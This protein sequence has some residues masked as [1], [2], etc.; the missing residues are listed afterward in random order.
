MVTVAAGMAAESTQ[1]PFFK[2]MTKAAA[3]ARAH[4]GLYTPA[5]SPMQESLLGEQPTIDLEQMHRAGFL[6]VPWTVDDVPT[7][8]LLGL[9]PL[10]VPAVLV[11]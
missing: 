3:H 6:V 8:R 9:I 5:L 1:N 4:H 2:L 7:M 11:N 10:L